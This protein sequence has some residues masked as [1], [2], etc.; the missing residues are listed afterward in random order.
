MRSLLYCALAGDALWALHA[1]GIGCALCAT[2]I[3]LLMLHCAAEARD[4]DAAE[5]AHAARRRSW[6]KEAR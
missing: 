6:G 5:A 4:A 2:A 3:N 1:G